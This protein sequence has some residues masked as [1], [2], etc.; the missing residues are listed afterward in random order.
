M[1]RLCMAWVAVVLVGGTSPA[2]AAQPW[3]CA[4]APTLAERALCAHREQEERSRA[5]L[6]S[7]V[8]PYD[9]TN[10]QTQLDLNLCA[11]DDFVR[12]DR[13]LNQAYR[14]ALE[15]VTRLADEKW[16]A[17]LREAQ[18]AWIRYR[19]LACR[20]HA[21]KY[22]GGS[23]EPL[24]EFSCLEQLSRRRTEDLEQLVREGG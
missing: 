17:T 18:R 16:A 4:A 23:I 1:A 12:A 11:R 13:A 9:C 15:F 14:A 2:P 24:V 19:D 21:L 7:R 8:P 22:D 5:G 6:E 3:P 20:T 10:Q